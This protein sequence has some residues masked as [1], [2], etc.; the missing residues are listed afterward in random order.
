MRAWQKIRA[1][2]RTSRW[3]SL[4]GRMSKGMRLGRKSQAPSGRLFVFPSGQPNPC[5]DMFKRL[6]LIIIVFETLLIV[7]QSFFPKHPE[8]NALCSEIIRL[9]DSENDWNKQRW[10]AFRDA[11]PEMV[12]VCKF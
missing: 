12:K 9:R 5:K 1:R 8:A 7:H 10:E 11:S 3:G 4:H 2:Y 6:L